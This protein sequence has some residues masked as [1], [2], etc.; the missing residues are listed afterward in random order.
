RGGGSLLSRPTESGATH[1]GPSAWTK[2]RAFTM[3]EIL[4]SL[5]II[6][7]VAAITLPSLTGNINER[8]WNTQ[9]KALYARF[10]QAIALMPALNGYGTLSGTIGE[11]GS[12]SIDID[13]VAET[14]ITAGLSKVLKIN[15]ICDNEHYTDC[16]LPAKLTTLNA[17]IISM[18]L[19]MKELNPQMISVTDT[20]Y[21]LVLTHRVLDTKAAA[22]ETQNGESILL[23]YN[24]NCIANMG[25]TGR[26]L[27][28]PKICANMIYDLNGAKGPNTVGKDMGFI[29]ILYPSDSV[30]VAPMPYNRLVGRFTSEEASRACTNEVGSEYRLPTKDELAALFAN[31]SILG[32]S[33]SASSDGHWYSSSKIAS[34]VNWVMVQGFGEFR[35]PTSAGEWYSYCVKR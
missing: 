30:V 25:E 1:C 34:N 6:G 4:L 14:F 19:T 33:S 26:Y 21:S 16:G 22:F 32:F 3:A 2:S 29:T 35:L 23:F 18:P 15:N 10:S 7:V 20:Q 9:R 31:R 11:D 5:T 17:S 13:N 12:Q 8:T 28:Q 27:V 24:P